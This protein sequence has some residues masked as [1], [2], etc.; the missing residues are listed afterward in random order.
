MEVADD[1]NYTANNEQSINNYDDKFISFYYEAIRKLIDIEDR[2][3]ASYLKR[4][5]KIFDKYSKRLCKENLA[6]VKE[7]FDDDYSTVVNLL[8]DSLYYRIAY[9]YRCSA[10][11]SSAVAFHFENSLKIIPDY[12]QRLL[13]KKSLKICSLGGGP[14]SDIVA[15][16]TVLESLAEKV[17]ILLD[18]RVT[19]IDFDMRWKNTCYTV[20]SCLE[21]FQNAT[22]KISFIKEDL[23][24]WKSY[25]S[26]TTAAMQEA[27][28][29]SMVM[30]LSELK[31]M[32]SIQE[33]TMKVRINLF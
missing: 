5:F 31:P 4:Y 22:W 20:L 24:N 21:Q 28:I 23:T 13:K 9:V 25:T 14:A 17:G 1:S 32:K 30:F 27:D 12:F 16:V 19:I 10:F 18:F 7:D 33:K 8:K 3:I 15:I 6:I 2:T 29:V 26:K 11:L